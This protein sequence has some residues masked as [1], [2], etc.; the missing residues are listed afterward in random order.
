MLK[1]T[2]SFSL[3][4]VLVFTVIVSMFFVVAAAVTTGSL[5]NM[6]VNEHKL[7]ATHY[8]RQL[9]EW[10]RS[11]K[12]RDWGGNQYSGA[13]INA[14]CNFTEQATKS[15]LTSYN[16]FNSA[17][18]SSW[19]ASYASSNP[20]GSTYALS[21]TFKRDV[22]FTSAPVSGYI[23]QV[24]VTITVTWVELGGV[25]NN[26]TIKTLFNQLEQQ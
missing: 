26:V 7:V 19:P 4:E 8:A 24:N 18:V 1:S 5:R 17:V 9:E 15:G 14:T 23:G 16:C 2:K 10:L 20:C 6:K 21:S 22:T 25:S 3:V 13:C 12:E 11:E